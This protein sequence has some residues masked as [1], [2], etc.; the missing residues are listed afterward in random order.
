MSDLREAAEQTLELLEFLEIGN[1]TIKPC[2][3]NLRQALAQPEQECTCSAKDMPFGRCCKAQPEPVAWYGVD[4]YGK[5]YLGWD[6]YDLLDEGFAWITPLY[7]AP[8]KREWVDLTE[9]EIR[10]FD[11]V[12]IEYGYEHECWVDP[13][14]LMKFAKNILQAAKEKNT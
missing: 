3:E 7:T 14:S 1:P 12:K 8:P 11:F 5:K 13:K 10:S 4:D 2:T 9:E 6:K